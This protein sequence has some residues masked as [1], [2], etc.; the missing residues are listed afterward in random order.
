[1]LYRN[2]SVFCTSSRLLS[3]MLCLEQT[4]ISL[5][6]SM[7]VCKDLTAHQSSLLWRPP[8][9]IGVI[10]FPSLTFWTLSEFLMV[11][12]P[13]LWRISDSSKY[14]NCTNDD[15]MRQEYFPCNWPWATLLLKYQ[16]LI[17]TY[18]CTHQSFLNSP[19][20][21]ELPTD[22]KFD[23][24]ILRI[25]SLFWGGDWN[26]SRWRR[27]CIFG[28]RGLVW[29]NDR[30]CFSLLPFLGGYFWSSFPSFP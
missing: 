23:T 8:L 24:F 19:T 28:R 1:M 29:R 11:S 12:I 17:H 10:L 2:L 9:K 5:C 18:A 30:T 21:F 27:I 6:S 14:C 3:S 20:P 4:V 22:F 7:L 13:D 15:S 25:Q 26:R 16:V